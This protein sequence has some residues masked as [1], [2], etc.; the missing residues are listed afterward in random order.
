MGFQGINMNLHMLFMRCQTHQKCLILYDGIY[1]YSYIYICLKIDIHILSSL[2]NFN[3]E[4]DE[5]IHGFAATSNEPRWIAASL[6]EKTTGKT[7][8]HKDLGPM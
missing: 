4:R 8:W 6:L 5:Q 2:R 1:I 3:V 7:Y